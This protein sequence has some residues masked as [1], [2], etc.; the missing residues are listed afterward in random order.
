[1]LKCCL[2]TL[3][4]THSATP[5]FIEMPI[6][7]YLLISFFFLIVLQSIKTKIKFNAKIAKALATQS[8]YTLC[9]VFCYYITPL[10]QVVIISIV[11]VYCLD[12]RI[13]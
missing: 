11:V 12:R 10:W 5:T 9:F 4:T 7:F 6:Q 13:H 2:I 8:N 3:T 1:M